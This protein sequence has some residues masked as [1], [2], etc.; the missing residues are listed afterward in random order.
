[1]LDKASRLCKKGNFR[2]VFA[3]RGRTRRVAAVVYNSSR[4]MVGSGSP[5]GAPV[6]AQ[7]AERFTRSLDGVMEAN[8]LARELQFNLLSLHQVKVTR[9]MNMNNM[10]L[11]PFW[12]FEQ[13]SVAS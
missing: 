12:T 9:G 11:A 4:H 6:D 10:E 3:G 7:R 13:V 5:Q 2:K 8:T 1:M